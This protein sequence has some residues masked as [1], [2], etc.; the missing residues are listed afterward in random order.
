VHLGLPDGRAH[1]KAVGPPGRYEGMRTVDTT[2]PYCG[3]GCTLTVHVK[4]SGQ[5]DRPRLLERLDRERGLALR[6]GPLRL[7]VREQP[8]PA[9]QAAHPAGERRVRGND[10]DRR[11]RVYRD[12][13]PAGPGKA[14]RR[15]PLPPFLGPLHHEEN[16]LFRSSCAPR[17]ARTTWTT[18]QGSD[19]P[20]RLAGL[21]AIFGS[22]AM[23]NSIREI[24]GMEVLFII[25]SNTK[26]THPVIATA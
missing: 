9:D 22:G 10:L 2:C 7:P 21:A 11:D 17:S 20:P 14:R 12:L 25:G 18:A 15:T 5:P 4:G 1:R 3:T 16:Y 24:E 19:T 26:E 13:A 6:Q 8:G 23:T